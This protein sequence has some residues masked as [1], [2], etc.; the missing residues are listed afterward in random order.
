MGSKNKSSASRPN[1]FSKMV[2]PLGQVYAPPIMSE[3]YRPDEDSMYLYKGSVLAI[4]P[5]PKEVHYVYYHVF[6]DQKRLWEYMSGGKPLHHKKNGS[7]QDVHDVFVAAAHDVLYY[8]VYFM[9]SSPPFVLSRMVRSF[10]QDD[11]LNMVLIEMPTLAP[12]MPRSYMRS[13]L[14]FAGSLFEMGHAFGVRVLGIDA[15]KWR[16]KAGIKKDK[17][18]RAFLL[19]RRWDLPA[20]HPSIHHIDAMSMASVFHEASTVQTNEPVPDDAGYFMYRTIDGGLFGPHDRG[21]WHNIEGSLLW[22]L[23]GGSDGGK[24][25]ESHRLFAI[26]LL[27][28]EI[29]R[30]LRELL[31]ENSEGEEEG[32]S[33]DGSSD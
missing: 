6:I 5:G 23:T 10:M 28:K 32:A 1:I 18:T 22:S 31:D 24:Q 25:D 26:Y 19:Q 14:L 30:S 8:K 7:L 33:A 4:D 13:M 21:V 29:D 12:V 16:L 27:E 9:G 3:R 15:Q 11:F 17:D 2:V 20:G